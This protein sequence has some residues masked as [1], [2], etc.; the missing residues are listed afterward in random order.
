M[1]DSKQEEFKFDK[2][3][4]DIIKREEAERQRLKEYAEEHADSPQRQYDRLYREK[5]QNR[6]RHNHTPKRGK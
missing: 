1:S 3:M 6:V 4:Q 5:W 2:F